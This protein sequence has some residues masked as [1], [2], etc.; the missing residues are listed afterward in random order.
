MVRMFLS[1]LDKT[2]PIEIGRGH[3]RKCNVCLCLWPEV[4]FHLIWLGKFRIW[5]KSVLVSSWQRIYY[6]GRQ[7]LSCRSTYGGY[8]HRGKEV[9]GTIKR[10][11]LNQSNKKRKGQSKSSTITRTRAPEHQSSWSRAQIVARPTPQGSDADT[12]SPDHLGLGRKFRLARPVRGSGA[13]RRFTQSGQGFRRTA[14]VPM[15]W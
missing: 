15:T 9:L 10:G 1:Q 6:A 4:Y 8:A 11:Y 14:P 3:Y 13:K 12:A 2:I 5:S 7:T